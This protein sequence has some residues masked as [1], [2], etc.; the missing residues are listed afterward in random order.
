MSKTCSTKR[1]CDNK[2]CKKCYNKS[3]ASHPKSKYWSN[4]NKLSPREVFK[5]TKKEF[6]LNC[7]KCNHSFIS[8]LN[9]IINGTWCPFCSNRKLCKNNKCKICYNKSF[10]SHPK[11]IFWSKNNK[12]SP[13]EV[14]KLSGSKYLFDCNCGHNFDSKLSKIANGSWCP[15]CS[16]PPQKL[17][18]NNSC[19]NCHEK[20]FISHPK[21]KYWS[22]KNKQTPR[23]TFN[24]SH[25][26]FIFFCNHCKHE[27]L[28]SPLGI[29]S[30]TWCSFCSN[31]TRQLCHDIKCNF[32]FNESF[33]SH[34][35][36]KLWSKKNKF[37]PRHICKFSNKKFI[38]DC[39]NC[40]HIFETKLN[41]I[42]K[43]QWCP[44]C[45]NPSRK[46]CCDNECTNCYE[47]SFASHNKSNEWNQ[48]KNK[49]SPREVLKKSN[50]EYHFTCK[51]CNHK[52]ITSPANI[53]NNKTCM[54]CSNYSKKLC[55]NKTCI[56]CYNK[57]FA[58]H[59]K[60]KYWDKNNKIIP[61]HIF[62]YSNKKYKF[63][64]NNCNNIFT[65]NISNISIG[66]WC[67]I[68]K[69]KTE[70]KLHKWLKKKYINVSYQKKYNWC[71]NINQ[72]PYDFVL[73]DYKIIIELD[74]P[75]HFIQISNWK[76]PNETHKIDLI[77]MK[78]GNKNGYTIIRLLQKD[79]HKDTIN[80]KKKLD[81]HIKNN[82]KINN[83]F[84][85]NNNEYKNF[86]DQIINNNIFIKN[87][88]LDGL[89]RLKF[90]EK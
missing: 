39:N 63:K 87:K 28:I 69:N 6:I 31:A 3:F 61:R 89:Q 27:F 18:N 17:C 70:K 2:K 68:C 74:G 83:V 33:A 21:S 20:S 38:F 82:K 78:E 88:I 25:K 55:K 7:N 12:I 42:N 58:S 15:F 37:N 14:F 16:N 59:P 56:Q 8:K 51:N 29:N 26:K 11:S 49:I 44:F 50:N 72:L 45:S 75:Q 53:T 30:G 77:K 62:K 34:P 60:S 85:C 23:Q 73:E 57:S 35:K 54:Y 1:L 19:I 52:Y 65:S 36:S 79:V 46:L 48:T 40:N 76:N 66:H 71:K 24:M 9:N 5:S 67:P 41:N 43:G 47:K 80:W 4:K 13:R 81:K 64:C 10:A 86:M 84:I 22:N 32:C 90:L